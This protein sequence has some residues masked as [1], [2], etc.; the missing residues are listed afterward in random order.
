MKTTEFLNNRVPLIRNS[1][2]ELP[3][4]FFKEIILSSLLLFIRRFMK[5]Y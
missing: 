5:V 3:C 1:N 2:S 4:I